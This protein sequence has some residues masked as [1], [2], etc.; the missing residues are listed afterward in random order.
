MQLAIV[1][2]RRKQMW[3]MSR[4]PSRCYRYP[5]YTVLKCNDGSRHGSSQM[6]ELL[7]NFFKTTTRMLYFGNI[8]GPC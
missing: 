7:P 5:F 4:L 6:N 8:G 1:E 3:V 2:E